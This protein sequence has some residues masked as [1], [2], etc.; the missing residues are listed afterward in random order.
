VPAAAVNPSPKNLI[1]G[2][3]RPQIPLF[4]PD[5]YGFYSGESNTAPALFKIGSGAVFVF[6]TVV[7][8]LM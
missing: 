8:L 4:G 1:D 2:Q 3:D 7:I 5:G 6:A